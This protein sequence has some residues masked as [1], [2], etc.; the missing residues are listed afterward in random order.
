MLGVVSPSCPYF[1]TYIVV[2]DIEARSNVLRSYIYM[3]SICPQILKR[4]E[5]VGE[6]ARPLTRPLLVCS[7]SRAVLQQSLIMLTAAVY[8]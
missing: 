2:I 4:L 5:E 6:C 1:T 3:F 8:T 7:Q